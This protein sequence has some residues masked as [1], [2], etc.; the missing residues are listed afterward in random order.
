MDKP[1]FGELERER[2]DGDAVFA[3][4]INKRLFT[5]WHGYQP[6]LPTRS[7]F[8]ILDHIP[9]AEY[10]YLYQRLA[11]GVFQYRLHGEQVQI[12]TGERPDDLVFSIDDGVAVFAALAEYLEMIVQTG[13]P[14]RCRGSLLHLGKGHVA[15]E[16]IDLP[17]ADENGGISHVIGT[18][19]DVPKP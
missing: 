5:W 8:D 13:H 11:P 6:A 19:K 9:I 4:A 15:F 1:D 10:I 18:I 3:S 7:D 14:H 17:L 2:L 16:S 12:L